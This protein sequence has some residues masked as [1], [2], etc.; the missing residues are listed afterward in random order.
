MLQSQLADSLLLNEPLIKSNLTQDSIKLDSLENELNTINCI[1]TMVIKWKEIWK[2]Y[3]KFLKN[4]EVDYA[5]RPAILS[6][7]SD[8]ADIYGD[9]IYLVRALANTFN[10]TY[11]DAFD[12]CLTQSSQRS[13]STTDQ[14]IDINVS[15]NPTNGLVKFKLPIDYSGQAFLFNLDGKMVKSYIIH[16]GDVKSIDLS[17]LIGVYFIQFISDNGNVQ[18]KKIIVLK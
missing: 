15:P 2:Q 14:T 17:D 1:D 4:G 5:D 6:L 13:K 3:I 9:A 8:C 16:N 7:S 11:F 18:S 12:G 10:T